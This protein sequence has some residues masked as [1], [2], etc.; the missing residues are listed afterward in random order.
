[1][2][3]LALPTSTAAVALSGDPNPGELGQNVLSWD[4]LPVGD[5]VLDVQRDR[6]PGHIER[7]LNRV[8]LPP[9][10]VRAAFWC[11]A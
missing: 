1:M 10:K 3:D 6:V 7:R 5:Q 2:C 4:R 9:L 11:A 8:A